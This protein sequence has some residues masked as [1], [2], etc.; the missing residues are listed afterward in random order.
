MQY[1]ESRTPLFNVIRSIVPKRSSSAI[2]GIAFNEFLSSLRHISISEGFRMSQGVKN[3][4]KGRYMF[5]ESS[6]IVFSLSND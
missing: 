1:N 4:R 2:K 3:M 6:S 5:V